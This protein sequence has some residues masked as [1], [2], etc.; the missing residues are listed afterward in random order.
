MILNLYS[1]S[2][3][4]LQKMLVDVEQGYRNHLANESSAQS[5]GSHSYKVWKDLA[6]GFQENIRK[7]QEAIRSEE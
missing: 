2:K 5:D 7:I 4:A 3:E 1:C 6:F